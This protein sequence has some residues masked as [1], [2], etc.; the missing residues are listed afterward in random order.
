MT[1]GSFGLEQF[2]TILCRYLA[3]D[4]Y[5]IQRIL[6]TFA[7]PSIPRQFDTNILIS[8]ILFSNFQCFYGVRQFF[9]ECLDSGY[10][11]LKVL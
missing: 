10:E 6:L 1:Y 2:L 4:H 8:R 9:P 3:P 7:L 11:L 5:G